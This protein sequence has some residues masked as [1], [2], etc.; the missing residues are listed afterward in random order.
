[1]DRYAKSRTPAYSRDCD[2]LLLLRVL[3]ETGFHRT[4]QKIGPAEAWVG[5]PS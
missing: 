3:Y 1:M 5:K 4:G 2:N